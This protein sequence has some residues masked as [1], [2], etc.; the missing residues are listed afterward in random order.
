MTRVE[1]TFMLKTGELLL[2]WSPAVCRMVQVTVI[3]AGIAFYRIA[4]AGVL[5]E[6]TEA[7]AVYLCGGIRQV[8]TVTNKKK[9]R[10]R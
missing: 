10:N 2:P 4:N 9:R 3:V 7:V 1:R 6:V 5:D 8:S